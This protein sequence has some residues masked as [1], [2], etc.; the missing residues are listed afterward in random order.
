MQTMA[1]D[2]LRAPGRL[3]ASPNTARGMPHDE[4]LP[5]RSSRTDVPFGA[6][7][8]PSCGAAS[9][10]AAA[11]REGAVGPRDGLA[12]VHEPPSGRREEPIEQ[13]QEPLGSRR[14]LCTQHDLALAAG[15]PG[16]VAVGVVGF[17]HIPSMALAPRGVDHSPGSAA[18]CFVQGWNP[19]RPRDVEVV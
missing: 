14:T 11:D 9:R 13:R 1:T 7:L 17:A 2:N 15:S 19:P 10:R 5:K 8:G 3:G 12:P 6:D 18:M 4:V 16:G